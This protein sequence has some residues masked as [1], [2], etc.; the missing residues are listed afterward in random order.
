MQTDANPFAFIDPRLLQFPSNKLLHCAD[1]DPTTSGEAAVVPAETYF[2]GEQKRAAPA[3]AYDNC[4]GDQNRPFDIRSRRGD[5]VNIEVRQQAIHEQ[6][7]AKKVP[8]TTQSWY[9]HR[10]P[11]FE[12]LLSDL[13]VG[14]IY[15]METV[16]RPNGW[17]VVKR[18]AV[19]GRS[20][21][22]VNRTFIETI[23]PTIL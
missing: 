18:G 3:W 5:R 20:E 8:S 9:G 19:G 22:D 17:P 7:R 10:A 23:K 11:R 12:Q 13:G 2:N 15:E 4:F 1:V 14:R 16:K 21:M 6:E